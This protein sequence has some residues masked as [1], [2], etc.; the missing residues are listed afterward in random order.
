VQTVALSLPPHLAQVSSLICCVFLCVECTPSRLAFVFACLRVRELQALSSACGA[1]FGIAAAHCHDDAQDEERCVL[2]HTYMLSKK[3]QETN[4]YS[5]HNRFCTLSITSH[6]SRSL[7]ALICI[8]WR[9]H[10]RSHAHTHTHTHTHT[11]RLICTTDAELSVNFITAVS[12]ER[13]GQ[14]QKEDRNR[15]YLSLSLL[16]SPSY[17]HTHEHTHTQTHAHTHTHTHPPTHKH[18]ATDTDTQPRTRTRTLT[19]I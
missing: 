11:C 5:M 6:D 13:Q 16:L 19:Q 15:D 12:T 8:H 10:A 1:T 17:T 3:G 4:G 7:S 9:T 14:K 18:T 2:P